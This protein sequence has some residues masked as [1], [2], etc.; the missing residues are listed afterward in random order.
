MNRLSAGV[1]PLLDKS[2]REVLRTVSEPLL[3]KK[4]RSFV[5]AGI[6]PISIDSIGP[7]SCARR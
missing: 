2:T 3:K 7:V 5:I 1:V 6:Y 4:D